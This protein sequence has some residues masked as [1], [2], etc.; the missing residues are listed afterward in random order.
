MKVIGPAHPGTTFAYITD[1][2]PCDG[3]L[4]LAMDCD[5]IYHEATFIEAD[6]QRAV[7][8]K[9]STAHEAAT[10]AKEANVKHLLIGH[11]SGRYKD[12][13]VLVERSA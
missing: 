10:I 5:L 4:Q 9:H 12:P 11:F 7:Q 8:T 13:S 2:M 3:A 1:T 6:R